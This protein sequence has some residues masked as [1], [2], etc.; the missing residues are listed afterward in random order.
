[1]GIVSP[2][3]MKDEPEGSGKDLATLSDG[4][5]TADDELTQFIKTHTLN[6]KSTAFRPRGLTNRSNWCFCNAILQGN[7]S[8][9]EPALFLD[10]FDSLLFTALVAC[11]P[12]FNFMR[13]MPLKS[14]ASRPPMKI[15]SAIWSFIQDIEIMTSFPK[16]HRKKAE[17]LPLG[18][19]VEA[20]AVFNMLLELNSDTFHVV[21]GRQEDAEEFLTFLLNGINDE[22]SVLLKLAEKSGGIED[23]DEAESSSG[24][25]DDDGPEW[26]EVR[27]QQHHDQL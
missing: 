7:V 26:K 11:P 21:E 9:Q 3:T 2:Y 10:S 12:F 13:K 1:M 5:I 14:S 15:T 23:E 22:I 16:F 17:D 19:T 6:H 25:G 18:K 8:P 20:A 4:V 27:Q 24:V